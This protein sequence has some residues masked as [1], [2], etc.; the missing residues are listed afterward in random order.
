MIAAPNR[1]LQRAVSP[2]P[3]FRCA[4]AVLFSLIL[5]AGFS[6]HALATERV[7]SDYMLSC[8][9]CH[10]PDGSGFPQRGVPAFPGF[11]GRFL[12]VEGGREFLIRVPGVAQS[13]LS[14]ERLASLMNWLLATYSAKELPKDFRSFTAD[15]V[16]Q[17]RHQPLVNVTATRNALLE[18]ISR[19]HSIR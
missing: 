1:Y 15:E 5:A 7:V 11:V 8:Q 6:G 19:I 13:A 2:A 16:A 10:L 3:T 18:K 12:H 4:G 17:W 14:D 9:G